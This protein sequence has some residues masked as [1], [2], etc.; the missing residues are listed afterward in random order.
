RV[1]LVVVDVVTER[2][3]GLHREL[4]HLLSEGDMPAEEAAPLYASA[5]R[6]VKSDE[7]WRLEV[8]FEQLALGAALPT[9]PLWLAS[10]LAIPVELESPYAEACSILRIA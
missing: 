9:L 5:Y 2:R 10:D 4:F 7:A 6:T 8:W 3:D 1:A